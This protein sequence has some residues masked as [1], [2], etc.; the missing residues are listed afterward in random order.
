MLFENEVLFTELTWRKSESIP[1]IAEH[2]ANLPKANVQRPRVV[3]ITQGSSPT[4]IA[5]FG[6]PGYKEI[7]V[8]KISAEEIIDTT[9][10][11]W[12]TLG[13]WTSNHI[14]ED[15]KADIITIYPVMLLQEDF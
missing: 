12:V 6:T 7:P 9:G 10:A 2:L 15:H 1:A 8:R 5:V 13:F 3:L 11:G 14:W 4:V